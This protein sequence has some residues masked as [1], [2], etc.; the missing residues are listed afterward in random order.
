M[1]GFLSREN[2]RG[3]REILVS[4]QPRSFFASEI[5]FMLRHGILAFNAINSATRVS[6]SLWGCPAA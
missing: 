4:V 5:T 2:K 3:V 1:S 6:A